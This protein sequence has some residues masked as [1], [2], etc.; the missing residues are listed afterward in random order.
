MRN[1]TGWQ[2]LNNSSIAEN[3]QTWIFAIKQIHK[4]IY[5]T[6]YLIRNICDFSQITVYTRIKCTITV[7]RLILIKF[8]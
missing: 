5:K 3:N 6:L 4:C 2:C 8:Y 1:V 7:H